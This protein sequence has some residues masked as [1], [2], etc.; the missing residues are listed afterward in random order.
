MNNYL[1]ISTTGL[2]SYVRNLD[3]YKLANILRNNNEAVAVLDFADHFNTK[4]LESMITAMRSRIVFFSNTSYE[5]FKTNRPEIFQF[6]QKLN[7]KTAVY[8][9]LENKKY[10]VDYVCYDLTA[11]IKCI[12][13]K[14]KNKREFTSGLFRLANYNFKY[15]QDDLLSE[16]DTLSISLSERSTDNIIRELIDNYER[17]S[18]SKYIVSDFDSVSYDDLKS[19]KKSLDLYSIR[20]ELHISVDLIFF[21]KIYNDFAMLNSIGVTSITVKI[22]EEELDKSI[23]VANHMLLNYPNISLTYE[24]DLHTKSS[25]KMSNTYEILKNQRL[26]NSVKLASDKPGSEFFLGDLN[27]WSAPPGEELFNLTVFGIQLDSV[28]S[29]YTKKIDFSQHEYLVRLQL[30]KYRNSFISNAKKYVNL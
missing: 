20:L 7:I 28:Y 10:D 27:K 24:L 30:E 11:V 6:L 17:F 25:P 26:V 19:L 14:N 3:P 8:L 23:L 13:N 18:I 5:Y 21:E 16:F 9:A 1:V 12:K 4:E 29:K 15:D 22:L 2:D